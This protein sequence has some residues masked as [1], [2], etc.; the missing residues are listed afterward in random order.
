[1]IELCHMDIRH[2]VIHEFRYLQT[3]AQANV[4]ASVWYYFAIFH[5]IVWAQ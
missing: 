5:E 2:V 3:V 1:M 4:V